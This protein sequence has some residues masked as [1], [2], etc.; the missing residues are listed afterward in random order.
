MA[1]KQSKIDIINTDIVV[2]GGGLAGTA[3]AINIA[4][5]GFDIVHLAPLAPK[6]LR[7]SALMGPSMDI[8]TSSGL[9]SD[10]DS[11][12]TPLTKI[13][14]IDATDRLIR[15]P[16]ALFDAREVGY[17]S[18]GYN[19]A[20][21]DL[22]SS[23]D[24]QAKKL[25]NYSRIKAYFSSLKHDDNSYLVTTNDGLEIKC[26]LIVG[27]DG[28]KSPVREAAGISIKKHDYKQ[29]ALVC[30]LELE[31]GIDET[32][33]E[34]HHKNGP[35]TLV[36]AGKNIANLVWIDDDF[37]L[38]QVK[39]KGEKALLDEFSKY[40]MGLFGEIKLLS[41]AFIFPLATFSA[42]ICGKD[43]VVLLGEAAHGFPPVGAQGLNLSLRDIIALVD[44]LR[45]VDK[46]NNDW[47]KIAA[48]KYGK[49]RQ[50]DLKQ[51]I[52]MVD[53]LFKS[54]LSDFLPVQAFRAGGIWA[55]KTLPFL[56]KKGFL[57][58]MGER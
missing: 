18:F 3:A 22:L 4:K 48:D 58:G 6:D 26:K 15:A 39:S 38:N 10:P 55:L 21:N 42:N 46:A 40:S 54:L 5:A 2:V 51:T 27:A 57:V 44:I 47:A 20:N 41:K 52:F 7:T 34:F 17:K 35:F 56:R 43:G 32:S 19:L 29:S 49:Q 14:I 1:S 8:L 25:K 36:P 9:V 24:E 33:I 13:R 37:L 28:K 31:R 16:E 45:Q 11:I 23:F 53:G 50:A 30:D 12:G